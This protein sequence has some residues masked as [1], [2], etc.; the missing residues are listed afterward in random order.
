MRTR[1][2]NLCLLAC[3]IA[4]SSASPALAQ[5]FGAKGGLNW[6]DLV[7]DRSDAAL[8]VSPRA[9]LVAGGFVTFNWF[10][11]LGLQVE[12]LFTERK[13]R[14]EPI[15][16]DRL[17]YIEIPM[18]ARYRVMGGESMRVFAVGGGSLSFLISASE[19]V[20]GEPYDVKTAF[21]PRDF[22]A[23][24]GADV[25]WKAR[26]VFG[27]RYLYGVGDVYQSVPAQF[28][29]TQRSIQVTAGI[30]LR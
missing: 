11:R 17:R 22:G 30:R 23:V 15:V 7:Y 6:P 2:F 27:V 4:L 16:R 3:V 21:E 24:V 9:G 19:S 10:G 18:L 5:E 13:T 20:G 29:A 28:Q 8:E 12:G 25:E 1:C 26:Y 14:V